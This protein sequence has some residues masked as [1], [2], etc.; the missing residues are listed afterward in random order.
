MRNT[1]VYQANGG[2][3]STDSRASFYAIATNSID[4]RLTGIS[5]IVNA[6]QP[7]SNVQSINIRIKYYRS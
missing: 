7:V 4:T 3:G 6:F 5:R 2:G 1:S